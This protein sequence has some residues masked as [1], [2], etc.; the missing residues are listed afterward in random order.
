[1]L[2]NLQLETFIR[3]ADTGSFAK[4]AKAL[5]VSTTAVI[6][7]MNALEG[8][9]G[10]AL[11]DRTHKGVFLTERGEALYRDAQYMI[12]YS[13]DALERVRGGRENISLLRVGTSLLTCRQMLMD[14]LF[15]VREYMPELQVQ[16]VPFE[17]TPAVFNATSV[18]IGKELDVVV[19]MCEIEQPDG[20]ATLPIFYEPVCCG[21]S[22][23][24]PLAQ[25]SSLQVR[26]LY[27]EKL[28]LPGRGYNRHIDMLRSELSRKHPQIRLME[29]AFIDMNLF[30]FCANNPVAIMAIDQWK[31][32][33][34]MLKIMPVE[35]DYVM[36]YGLLYSSHPSK[37][38][39]KFVE[40]VAR[41]YH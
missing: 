6:K 36:P 20:Y 17:N 12:Q 1:M 16:L 2:Y 33:H 15:R 35:W 23:N 9:L 30:N 28:M 8:S 38:T 13:Q 3:V 14:I 22:V 10:F 26:D 21:V 4:A 31:G 32:I 29:C 40:T 39:R 34:P 37:T 41:I 7:Q 11:F 18:N 24:H 27:G 5:Y 19:A 25:K